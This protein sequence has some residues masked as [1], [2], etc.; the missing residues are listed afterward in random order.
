MHMQIVVI[1]VI[2]AS[3]YEKGSSNLPSQTSFC[4]EEGLC[5]DDFHIF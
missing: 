3:K 5:T 2:K 1:N 4:F